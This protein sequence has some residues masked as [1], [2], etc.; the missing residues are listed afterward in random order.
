[1]KKQLAIIAIIALTIGAATAPHLQA[2]G[3]TDQIP[4][5][6]PA[7]KAQRAAEHQGVISSGPQSG[8]HGNHYHTDKTT[9]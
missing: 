2:A 5:Q 7:Q 6:S 9:R 3:A 1:M 8:G 4:G